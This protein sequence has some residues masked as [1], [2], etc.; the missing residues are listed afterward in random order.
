MSGKR[1]VQLESFPI[2]H[3]DLCIFRAIEKKKSPR[4]ERRSAWPRR[5]CHSPAHDPLIVNAKVQNAIEVPFQHRPHSCTNLAT[6]TDPHIPNARPPVAAATNHKTLLLVTLDVPVLLELQT[7]NTSI[8]APERA[9]AASSLDVPGLD[10]LITRTRDDSLAVK[11]E[12]IDAV[13]VSPEMPRVWGTLSPACVQG[14][15][16]L[17]QIAPREEQR[18]MDR[19]GA[20]E[21]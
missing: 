10:R 8:M 17:V 21:E 7:E 15:T 6:L 5:R 3:P 11:L 1:A 16:S 19:S 9:Q 13:G 2:P 20:W 4:V 14:R 18:R 12:T